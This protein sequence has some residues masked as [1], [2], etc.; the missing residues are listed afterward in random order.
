MLETEG[1]VLDSKNVVLDA[2][3]VVALDAPGVG[4]ASIRERLTAGWDATV[5]LG[6]SDVEEARSRFR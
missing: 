1:V 2:K 4:A 6:P 3:D 5:S